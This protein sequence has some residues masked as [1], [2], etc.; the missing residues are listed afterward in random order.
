MRKRLVRTVVTAALVGVAMAG[1]AWT[2]AAA[3]PNGTDGTRVTGVDTNGTRVTGDDTDG[4]RVTGGD[5]T[6]GTRVT[7]QP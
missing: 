7:G 5:S 6:D 2:A 3:T 1:T 4:T